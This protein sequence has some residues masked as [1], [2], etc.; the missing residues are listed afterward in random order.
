MFTRMHPRVPGTRDKTA[1]QT[2]PGPMESHSAQRVQEW[3]ILK[4]QGAKAARASLGI[5]PEAVARR[6]EEAREGLWGHGAA[7]EK[8]ARWR[9][10]SRGDHGLAAFCEPC[11]PY[12]EWTGGASALGP[13]SMHRCLDRGCDCRGSDLRLMAAG[14]NHH[15][16][17]GLVQQK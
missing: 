17:S 7:W 11:L 5:K 13:G 14:T 12:G 10:L 6:V 8:G 15:A 1:K 16:L 4:I 9:A 3:D 2:L